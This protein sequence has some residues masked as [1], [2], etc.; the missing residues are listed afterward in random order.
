[1]D[2]AD[3]GTYYHY[4]SITMHAAA[5][6]LIPVTMTRIATITAWQCSALHMVNITE[7]TQPSIQSLNTPILPLHTDASPLQRMSTS[8]HPQ[9]VIMGSQGGE[10]KEAARSRVYVSSSLPPLCVY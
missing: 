1:M 2:Q 10:N 5:P 4:Y 3:L 6:R 7:T 9:S 8:L